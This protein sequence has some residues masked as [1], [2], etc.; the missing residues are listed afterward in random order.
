MIEDDQRPVPTRIA[1]LTEK[2]SWRPYG[3]AAGLVALAT[4]AAFGVW[5]MLPLPNISLVFVV[6]VL[7][8]AI[9]C[10]LLPS[11][12]A[13]LAS[14][15]AYNFFFTEPYFTLNV[16]H[17][18]ELF[19]ILFFLVVAV[20]VGNLAARLKT[21]VEVMRTATKRTSNLYEFSRKIAA[22]SSLDDV[23]W[24]ATHHV[25]STLQ[26][27]S[28]VLL[29]D[30]D[31]HLQIAAGFPPEDRLSPV[32]REAA[33]RAWT[34]GE[35]TG[36]TSGIVSEV[37]WLF[38]P[39]QTRRGAVGLVGISF[40][41]K[42][43]AL[44]ADQRRLLDALADQVAVAVE[45][46]NLATDVEEA[47]VLSETE[48]LRSALLSSV[49]HDLR[50][51]LSSIIGSATS[52]AAYVDM[53][54]KG[55]RDQLIETILEESERLDRFVQNLLDMTRLGY[56]A[57]QPNRE[58]S[59][60]REIAGRVVKRCSR[61]L[62]GRRLD[63]AVPEDLP[64][65]FVDPV[66]VEQVLI[67]LLDNAIKYTEDDGWIELR[68]EPEG[69]RIAIRVS[70]DGPGIPP[71]AREAVFDMFYRVRG[72]DQRTAGTGLGLSICRGIVQAHG[73]RIAALD[74]PEGL[75]TTIAI[76]LPLAAMPGVAETEDGEEGDVPP[77]ADGAKA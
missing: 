13:S 38:L 67:N 34:K 24:A 57:V 50:T 72:R 8:T 32:D 12:F 76:E 5:Q 41:G 55:D 69:G 30:K 52:L 9:Y 23:L 10:G 63:L 11:I 77:A 56:G 66:L 74:G 62:G 18:H 37:G 64:A 15:L 25:A 43:F 29:P 28:L 45:R 2:F 53:I 58:W 59:D 16:F 39:L 7:L 54:S 31:G 70:D 68:A 73:G 49:S 60:L 44:N 48:R 22:A 26:C 14:F 27:R 35:P 75:G 6:A 36:L 51:P 61:L 65:V 19:T 21:Q 71:D 42:R 4:L 40:E 47:R 46:T 20:I 1:A 33:E 3:Y 17:R